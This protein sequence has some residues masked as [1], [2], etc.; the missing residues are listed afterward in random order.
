[1]VRT[2]S[3]TTQIQYMD[4]A[5]CARRP[6][7]GGVGLTALVS[8]KKDP[9]K[10]WAGHMASFGAQAAVVA[11]SPYYKLLI[12]RMLGYP[13]AHV[14]AH[15]QVGLGHA[16]H[17]VCLEIARLCAVSLPMIAWDYWL[18]GWVSSQVVVH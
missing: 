17:A 9:F 16:S 3:S 13:E 15:I 5:P 4:L 14:A 1:M 18:A 2:H 8:A 6:R 10:A 12:G 11:E 7:A